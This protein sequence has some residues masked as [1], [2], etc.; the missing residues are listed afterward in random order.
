MSTVCL[1][2]YIHIRSWSWKPSSRTIE[3]DSGGWRASCTGRQSTRVATRDPPDAD[4]ACKARSGNNSQYPMCRVGPR[5][6]R[7]EASG[8]AASPDSGATH[9]TSQPKLGWLV[10]CGN[11]T[12]ASTRGSNIV[13]VPPHDYQATASMWTRLHSFNSSSRACQH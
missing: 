3:F 5:R 7:D 11:D 8:E 1:H 10:T 2:R 9:C 6:E 13:R 4:N 12:V